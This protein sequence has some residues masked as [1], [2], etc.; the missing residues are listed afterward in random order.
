MADYNEWKKNQP[1]TE[2]EIDEDHLQRYAHT[3]GF[4]VIHIGSGYSKRAWICPDC[5]ALVMD[6]RRHHCKVGPIG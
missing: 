2:Q 3:K 6:P 5:S 1:S 4:Q